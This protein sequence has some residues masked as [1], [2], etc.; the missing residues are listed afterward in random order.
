MAIAVKKTC[1]LK[2]NTCRLRM[3]FLHVFKLLIQHLY[4]KYANFLSKNGIVCMIL[5][6][7]TYMAF[8]AFVVF[9]VVNVVLMLPKKVKSHLFIKMRHF[10][11]TFFHQR[12]M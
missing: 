6:K 12:K 4:Q 11:M 7:C 3:L 1:H 5:R 10:F 8:L 2:Q 9:L